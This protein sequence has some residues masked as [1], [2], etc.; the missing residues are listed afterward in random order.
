[1][2]PAWMVLAAGCLIS[3]GAAHWFWREAEQVDRTRFGAAVTNLLE[4]LDTRTERYAEQLERL[5][6]YVAVQESVTTA[7]WDELVRRI[8]PGSNLPAFVELAYATNSALLSRSEVEAKTLGPLRLFDPYPMRIAMG[9]Q[10]RNGTAVHGPETESRLNRPSGRPRWLR[11]LNGRMCSSLRRGIPGKDGREISAVELFVPVFASD[12]AEFTGRLPASH[13][14]QIRAFRCRGVVV[15]TLGW[16]AFLGAALPVGADQVAFDAFVG[17]EDGMPLAAETWLGHDG[18]TNPPTLS[19]GFAPRFRHVQ[20]WPFYRTRWQL[21]FH[22]T[23][24]FERQSNRYRAWVALAV[25]GALSALM[26]G[27]LAVQ[28]LGRRRQEVVTSRLK[29][30]LNALETA[31]NE[32]E[33]LSHDLHDG[34]IQSLYALQLGLSRA[35]DLAHEGHPLLASRLGDHVQ[36]LTSVIGELR[37]FIL[38][39]EV[40]PSVQQDLADVLFSLVG[41][42]RDT[43]EAELQTEIS[44]DA[45]RRLSGVQSVHLANAAREALSNSLRHSNAR[46]ITVILRDEGDR[47]TLEVSDDGDGFEP[48][49]GTQH[50]LGITSMGRRAAAAGGE[51]HLVSKPGQGCRVRLIV[52]ASYGETPAD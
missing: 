50:G 52:P 26:A 5:A 24:A 20:G 18:L 22:S 33:R 25:G 19:A 47:I 34:T 4:H 6:D 27:L 44:R 1:M 35:R 21:V 39:H 30:A 13:Q 3:L 45:A 36:N 41:C 28:I 37:G 16:N 40:A 10:W 46:R 9:P 38:R 17:I 29:E 14:E 8:D 12:L 48:V 32:R 51:L 23:P 49:A 11:V 42:L 31:R 43:T 2:A 15:G 7:V